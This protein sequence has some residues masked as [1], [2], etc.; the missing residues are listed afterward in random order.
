MNVIGT[1][2]SH[3]QDSKTTPYPDWQSAK[4]QLQFASVKISDGQ[5]PLPPAVYAESQYD[6]VQAGEI[7]LA[8]MGMHYY[9]SRAEAQSPI[10]QAENFFEAFQNLVLAVSPD[11]MF[12]EM[13]ACTDVESNDQHLV[14]NQFRDQLEKYLERFRQLSGLYS[15]IYTRALLW[16]AWV[17]S[18]KNGFTDIPRDHKLFVANYAVKTPAIPEDWL[19]RGLTWTLWQKGTRTVGG[20]KNPIDDD[21]YNGDKTAFQKE[22]NCTIPDVI[23]IPPPVP[24]PD[25]MPDAVQ[26]KGLVGTDVNDLLNM[27]NKVFGNSLAKT[28]NGTIWYPLQQEKD[29]SGR[30]WY[31]VKPGLWIASWYTRP[32]NLETAK[33]IEFFQD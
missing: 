23:V 30:Y 18:S 13:G 2:V 21:E 27:R 14:V 15:M 6:W 31:E 1:D 22:F 20:F 4:G 33:R 3:W 11:K 7:E 26:V 12:G 9:H 24:P 28:W 19:H 32:L 10:K 16:N 25:I 8:R 17:A 5:Q 29:K